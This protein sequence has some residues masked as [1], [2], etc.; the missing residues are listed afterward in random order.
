M[1]CHATEFFIICFRYFDLRIAVHKATKTLQFVH[2]MYA[3][4]IE[5][6][7]SHIREFLLNHQQEIVVLDIQHFYDFSDQHHKQLQVGCAL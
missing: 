6:P 5:P 3:E 2:G 4:E 1:V 7:F